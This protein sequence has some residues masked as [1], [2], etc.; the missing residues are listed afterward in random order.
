[1][2]S[3]YIPTFLLW[4]FFG[5]FGAHRF[6]WGNELAKY[7]LIL[8]LLGPVFFLVG[9]G[10]IMI[11]ALQIWWLIDFCLLPSIIAGAKEKRNSRNVNRVM[12]TSA[13][14]QPMQRPVYVHSV[15]V[16]PVYAQPAYAQPVYAQHPV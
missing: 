8:L 16:Q 12:V 4:F 13:I 10:F 9:V 3:D 15:P 5:L 11:I 14:A 2:P 6:F 7:Q 1:T